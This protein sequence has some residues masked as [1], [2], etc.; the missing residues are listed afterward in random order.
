M[1]VAGWQKLLSTGGDP[2]FP[3]SGLTLRAVPVSAGVV[4]DGPMPA[5]GALIEMPAQGGGVTA[6]KGP[7]HFE[8]LPAEPVAVLVWG[9]PPPPAGEIRRPPG[10]AGPPIRSGV[11]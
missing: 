11:F 2:P 9:R 8:V 7:Q 1:H 10:R 6:R 5:A 3:S 4:G